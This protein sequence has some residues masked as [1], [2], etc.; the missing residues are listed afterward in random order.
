MKTRV[1][2]SPLTTTRFGS[3][4]E[5]AASCGKEGSTMDCTEYWRL[6]HLDAADGKELDPEQYLAM[7]QHLAGCPDCRAKIDAGVTSMS[8]PT[9]WG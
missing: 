9:I 2:S 4:T 8:S 7:E 5:V 6:M 1:L 3:K